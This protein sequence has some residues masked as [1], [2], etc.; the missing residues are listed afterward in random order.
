[1]SQEQFEA[2]IVG[3]NVTAAKRKG[4]Q[5]YLCLDEGR[6]HLLVH[7]GMTGALVAKGK[8]F[9]AYKNGSMSIEDWPPRFC[10]FECVA[11]DGTRVA[12]VD[13]RRFGRALLRGPDAESV[14]PL[15]D[16]APDPLFSCPS[17]EIMISLFA[18][19]SAPIKAVILDQKALV[20]GVGN[21]VADEVLYQASILPATPANALNNEAV[22]AL[23]AALIDVV[24]VACAANADSKKFPKNWL[25]HYRWAKQ[26]SGSITSAIGRIH[27]ATVGGRT[28]AFL[29]DK[30]K[31][32]GTAIKNNKRKI[33][34]TTTTTVAADSTK[35]KKPSSSP[36]FSQADT[37]T[38]KTILTNSGSALDADYDSGNEIIVAVVRSKKKPVVVAK[39]VIEKKEVLVTTGATVD[40]TSSLRRSSRT[41][42]R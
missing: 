35:K 22:E 9:V 16:L 34:I 1:M 4:K 42:S 8:D 21:W 13:P 30:Q 26:T 2:A 39:Q 14:A 15:A 36:H 29:P 18:T 6:S 31:G 20:C 23:R 19:R 3:K 40:A 12:F 33:N 32:G 41:S 37:T 38:T 7:N 5:L 27:F 25:F 11:E 24:T 28:T 17:L 10:K